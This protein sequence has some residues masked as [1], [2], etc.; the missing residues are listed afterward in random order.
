[1]RPHATVHLRT[2]ADGW[3][4]L[5][6]CFVLAGCTSSV[7]VSPASDVAVDVDAIEAEGSR[8]VRLVRDV[9]V[10]W[11]INY[12]KL[13]S[14]AL[15]TGLDGTGSDPP[16]SPQRSAL[17]SEMQTREVEKP[18]R[19][20]ASPDTSL[21]LV[22]AYLPPGVQK[23]DPIDIEVRAPRRSETTSL[24]GGWLMEARLREM[25]ILNNTLRTGRVG[26]LASGPVVVDAVF[27]GDDDEMHLL[28]GRVLGGGVSLMSR[29]LGLV[30]RDESSS[31]RTSSLIATAINTRFH[32][33][34]RGTKR[35]VATPKRDNFV[36]LA[37]H[38]RYRHNLARYVR[39]VRSIAV[40]ESPSDRVRRLE[41]L[42][43]RL[44]QPDMAAAAA[45]ELEAIGAE[46]V[47]ILQRAARSEDPEVR[48]YAAEALAYMDDAQAAEPLG[49]AARSEPAFRWHAIAALSAMDDVGAH[50]AL[51][52]LLDVD[53]A[54]T[55]YGAFRALWMRNASDPLVRGEKLGGQ[56]SYHNVPSAG[57]PLVH[58][59]RRRRPEI[60]VFGN[61]VRLRPPPFLFAGKNLM[62]KE[63]ESDRLKIIRFSAR[64]EDEVKYCST[65]LD[66]VLRTIVELGGRYEDAFRCLRDAK[67][68]NYLDA[69][70]VVDALPRPGRTYRRHEAAHDT[71][72][73]EAV[74]SE[75]P[76]PQRH[77][78]SPLPDMFRSP[79]HD[80]ADS[81]EDDRNDDAAADHVGEAPEGSFLKKLGRGLL[82]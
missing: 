18:G 76:A 36:E 50:E 68:R 15:V 30:I 48:F 59:A 42:E 72:S 26:A 62:I 70:V 73:D 38:P 33:F 1:M 28:R 13:E 25:A 31:I 56:F 57:P 29:T 81:S 64:K 27:E 61:D 20:L 11:G 4:L 23:G 63:A 44:N 79:S 39:V 7:F 3:I 53:S 71:E 10:P 37:V 19:I 51:V 12:V 34:E 75:P 41:R 22:R 67:A 55:R 45:L 66:D 47:P 49:E 24:A 35:G 21:V 80:R 60:V 17:V 9:A 16:P 69:R 2:T 52:R 58:V 43:R 82:D 5:V 77:V 14:V 40:A 8:E 65:R 54:E 6:A 46:A 74:S 32:T 78:A